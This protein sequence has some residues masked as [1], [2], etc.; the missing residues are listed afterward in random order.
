VGV[1]GYS[2][3]LTDFDTG[4]QRPSGP[5]HR[6]APRPSAAAMPDLPTPVRA[7][8]QLPPGP[9]GPAASFHDEVLRTTADLDAMLALAGVTGAAVPSAAAQAAADE[10]VEVPDTAAGAELPAPE[11]AAAAASAARR[12]AHAPDDRTLPLLDPAARAAEGSA[13]GMD[14]TSIIARSRLVD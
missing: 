2:A 6:A 13:P 14:D 4:A 11:E 9:D 1:A 3:G 12:Q 8:A 5:R 7:Q 10:H